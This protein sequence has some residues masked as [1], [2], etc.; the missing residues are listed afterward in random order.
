MSTLKC[1]DLHQDGKGPRTQPFH[2]CSLWKPGKPLLTAEPGIT[3]PT[4]HKGPM[5]KDQWADVA[6]CAARRSVTAYSLA[7]S[8]PSATAWA[9][10][11]AVYQRERET[12]RIFLDRY[13]AMPYP[14]S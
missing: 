8:A 4:Y 9:G 13:R 1:N 14:L 12:Y 11:E 6:T 10:H 3:Y 2:L 7:I 5:T